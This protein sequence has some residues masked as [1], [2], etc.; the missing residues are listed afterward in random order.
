MPRE[1]HASA[2]LKLK[3]ALAASKAKAASLD[4]KTGQKKRRWRSG[5]RARMIMRQV[6]RKFSD[7]PVF[8]RAVFRRMCRRLTSRMGKDVYISRDAIRPMELWI[9]KQLHDIASDAIVGTMQLGRKKKPRKKMCMKMLR[10]AL[11]RYRDKELPDLLGPSNDVFGY[12][13]VSAAMH[14]MGI[15]QKE[16]VQSS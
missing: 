8:P 12:K 9:E 14:D 5:T 1:K 15:G 7:R 4:K 11:L 2:K 10:A 13:N 6:I 3:R 16:V